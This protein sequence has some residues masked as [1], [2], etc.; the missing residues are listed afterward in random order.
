MSSEGG[1]RRYKPECR[2]IVGAGKGKRTI[3]LETREGTS[4][5]QHADF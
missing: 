2:Q 1:G 5:D 4:P 3:L